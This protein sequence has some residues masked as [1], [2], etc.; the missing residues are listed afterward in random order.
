MRCDV[1]GRRS[2]LLDRLAANAGQQRETD[3]QQHGLVSD[4][5]GVDDAGVQRVRGSLG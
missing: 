2:A 4:D 3:A 5:I 1:A